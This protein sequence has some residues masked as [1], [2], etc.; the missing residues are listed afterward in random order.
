MTAEQLFHPKNVVTTF[1]FFSQVG[2]AG[3]IV[4]QIE[5]VFFL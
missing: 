2:A 3:I 5:D 1:F 4:R